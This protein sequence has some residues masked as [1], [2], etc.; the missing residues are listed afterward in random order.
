[1]T[2]R[3]SVVRNRRQQHR[4]ADLEVN[5]DRGALR[6]FNRQ[7]RSKTRTYH[8]FPERCGEIVIQAIVAIDWGDMGI[9]GDRFVAS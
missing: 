4:I 8:K 5:Q 1:M 6:N 9:D 3:S 2:M 7:W